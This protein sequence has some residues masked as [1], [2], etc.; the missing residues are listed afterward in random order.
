MNEAT[1]KRLVA[2]NRRFY[3]SLAQP[4]SETRGRLQP[5]VLR[6]LE[7]IGEWDSVLDLGC[8]NGEL[9]AELEARGHQGAYTGLDFSIELLQIARARNFDNSKARFEP[10]DL[11][12]SDWSAQ[13][14]G[15]QFDVIL[16]FASL[17]HIPSEPMRLDFLHQVR[18]LLAEGGRFIHSNWQFLKSE[19]LAKR[20]QS[21]TRAELDEA[22]VDDGDYLLDWKRGAEGLRYVHHFSAEELAKLGEASG[23]E[24]VETF[25]SDGETG[26]LGLYSIWIKSKHAP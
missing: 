7:S 9:A 21:W 6:V 13:L 5:G 11:S 3:Q 4:F 23:F 10:A 17:H 24:V 2:L 25:S 20:V 15:Q 16:C 19:R 22:D 14:A 12:G 18:R 26:D 1:A 8:G